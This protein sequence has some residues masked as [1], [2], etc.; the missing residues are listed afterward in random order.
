MKNIFLATLVSLAFFSVQ[1]Q[2]DQKAKAILDEVSAK[3]KTYKTISSEFS[4]T[5]EGKDKKVRTREE[6]KLIV[7][8]K[9]YKVDIAGQ[10]IFCDGK[11]IWTY[12]K[13][14]NEV[15]INSVENREQ[16]DKIT[17]SNIFT[18]YEKGFKYEFIKEETVKGIV[19][20]VINLY[21]QEPKK[22]AYHT[23]K[24]MIDKA[25]KQVSSLKISAKDGTTSTYALKKFE[26]NKEMADAVFA[27]NKA[28][29]PGVEVVDLRE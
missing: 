4:Y 14:S 6:G 26:V 1:A 13:E 17:P 9:M 27:F 16:D 5:V 11:T 20:Q 21:P 10:Q 12:L 15:Q 8:G 29:F 18:V 23:A 2:V 22:K 28:N 24:L 25:K 19:Y 3:T 7:K